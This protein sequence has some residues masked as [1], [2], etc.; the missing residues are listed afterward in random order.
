M[1]SRRALCLLPAILLGWSL[2]CAAPSLAAEQ[3]RF[4]ASGQAHLVVHRQLPGG[5]EVLA[6]PATARAGDL[7]QL[8]YV[9]AGQ[10]YGVI[11]SIDGRGHVTLHS[12][13][14]PH[15]SSRLPAAAKASLPRAFELDDAPAFERFIFI[16]AALPID[17]EAVLLAGYALGR[18][19][20]GA[21]TR[22][23]PLPT[24]CSQHSFVVHKIAALVRP[25]ST[26]DRP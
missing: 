15:Q 13:L 20:I 5:D 21:R 4:G 12:P 10:R 19:P 11:I 14:S 23:L 6:S 3:L 2:L 9:R 26:E 1:L 16:T 18:D 8:R 7:L 24:F 17:V 25:P 22:P